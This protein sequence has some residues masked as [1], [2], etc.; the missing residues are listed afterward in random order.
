[1]EVR[2]LQNCGDNGRGGRLPVAQ[3]AP[4]DSRRFVSP[5]P[6]QTQNNNSARKRR[7]VEEV[8]PLQIDLVLD[9][10]N[11]PNG[12]G[13]VIVPY[14]ELL[15][16]V[17]NNFVCKLCCE[18]NAKFE[19][20]QVGFATSINF[21]C[22]CNATACLKAKVRSGGK[23]CEDFLTKWKQA[24]TVTR[25]GSP[26]NAFDL[27]IRTVLSIQQFGG[28]ERES[29]MLG[30]ILD[31]AV[32]PLKNSWQAL[33]SEVGTVQRDLGQKSIDQNVEDEKELSTEPEKN[34]KKGIIVAGD[35]R[36]DQKGS[37]ISYN[38]D[39]GTHILV[40]TETGR[41]V[42]VHVMS[43]R[44]AKCES[45]KT[46]E[47]GDACSKN[48]DGS[49]KGMEATGAIQNVLKLF[50]EHG[51]YAAMLACDDDSS[52]KAVLQWSYK[53]LEFNAS[54]NGEVYVWPKTAGGYKKTDNGKLPLEHP[55]MFFLADKNHRVRTYARKYFELS[56]KPLKESECTSV[57]A[58]RIKRNFSYCVRMYS[59]ENFD[60]FMAAM[61]A[62]IEHHFNNHEFCGDW[63]PMKKMKAGSDEAKAA[64]LKYRCK[65]K[66]AKLYG[67]M[68]ETHDA[69]TTEEWLRDLHHD[70]HTNK[71]ESIN[72]FITKFMHK[73]KHWCRTMANASRTYLAV[74]ID[75]V[76]YLQCF[77]SMFK[78]LGLEMTPQ[79]KEQCSRWDTR[80]MYLVEYKKSAIYKEK[81]NKMKFEKLRVG[82]AKLAKDNARALTYASGMAGPQVGR[83]VGPKNARKNAM[84][85][86]TCKKSGH[87]M[88]TSIECLMST[89]PKSEHYKARKRL[90]CQQPLEGECV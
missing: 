61:K 53:D 69:F 42:A 13:N 81:K 48:Y 15:R 43:K 75:S 4:V 6:S 41:V 84:V 78:S 54:A 77:N 35:S 20:I 62:V 5:I 57:D 9:D 3:T 83:K 39:S 64:S 38:S 45:G 10:P 7:R 36:W 71:C 12:L 56:R 67:Q 24:T 19:R 21:V 76:G 30:G 88:V 17:T 72:G 63:C 28:G 34:G 23:N 74:L 60:V 65:V 44:C 50:N 11:R 14:D 86:K 73:N 2:K 55:I 87:K 31:I 66:N 47:E 59:G 18:S 22:A 85:C 89:N 40:G 27:N 29:A 79:T 82:K 37:G 32:D 58:E 1:M 26:T 46:H 70:V 52:S 16:F 68:K 90:E 49:S 51:C 33:E 80:R 8:D 25:Y